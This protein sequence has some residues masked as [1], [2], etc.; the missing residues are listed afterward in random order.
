MRRLRLFGTLAIAALLVG[1]HDTAGGPIAASAIS[2]NG[3]ARDR[4]AMRRLAG[5]EVTVWGFV[6]HGNLYGDASARQILGEWWS[7]DGPD[8]DS[9][10]FH[11][12]AD[13]GDEVGQSFAVRISNDEGRDGLLRA[14]V[15]DARAGRPTRVAVTGALR[16]FDAP[17][18]AA[19]RT[20]LLMVLGSSR[21]VS[22]E[23]PEGR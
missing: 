1:C 2:K 3:F 7:G 15:A 6:D 8:G 23:L 19:T 9:W 11:L 18:Q 12:K 20:G 17:T 13:A 10:S 4:E 14:F 16:T 22:I 5:T 21:A